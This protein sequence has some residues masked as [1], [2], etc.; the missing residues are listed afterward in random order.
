MAGPD[1]DNDATTG[2][3]P[4]EILR[5][6]DPKPCLQVL[7]GQRWRLIALK[8]GANLIGRG[9]RASVVIVHRGVSRRHVE[10]ELTQDGQALLVDQDSTNG[11]FVNGA[12]VKRM[13]LREGDR[14]QLG[15]AMTFRY[16]LY[17]VRAESPE[18]CEVRPL[19]PLLQLT[20]REREIA[21][22]VADGLSNT[23]IG[24][25]LYISDRTVGTHLGKIYKRLGIH[26]RVQLTRH[27]LKPG[28]AQ[29]SS[30]H[31]TPRT[32]TRRMAPTSPTRGVEK[33]ASWG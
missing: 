19:R 24:A 16:T 9:A 6:I 4:F 33:L 14:I 17:P 3:Q 2:R 7:D 27:V 21:Q 30:M 12:R 25:R 26:S 8:L 28:E 13:V 23:A 10:I 15:S 22:L 31:P 20:A 18:P 5:Q 1:V 11:T 32:S 29:P